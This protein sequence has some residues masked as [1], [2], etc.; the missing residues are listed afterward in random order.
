V[1]ELPCISVTPAVVAAIRAA[2]GR[3]LVR[4]PVRPDDLAP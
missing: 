1:G 3:A 2:T 4:V